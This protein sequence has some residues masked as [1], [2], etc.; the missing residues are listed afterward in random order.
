[1]NTISAILDVD[2]DGT[3]HLPVP[4]A[5]RAGK[6]SVTATL[7]A[8]GSTGSLPNASAAQLALRRT[9]LRSLREQGG[10]KAVAPDPVAWQR[11]Q[12]ADK[13]LPGRD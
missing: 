1:M 10:L 2:A 9:A 4:P 5:L 13:V 6:V 7:S 3:L 12:R 8:A 11:E